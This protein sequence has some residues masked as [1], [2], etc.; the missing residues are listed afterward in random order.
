MQ[1]TQGKYILIFL[2]VLITLNHMVLMIGPKLVSQF[3]H[4]AWRLT[5]SLYDRTFSASMQHNYPWQQQKFT[6]G[7]KIS[8]NKSFG[9]DLLQ[10]YM[11]Q[12]VDKIKMWLQHSGVKK[13]SQ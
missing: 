7:T 11:E 12:R 4:S 8:P 5:Q 3:P 2:E 10:N 6:K 13:R 9:I 1:N